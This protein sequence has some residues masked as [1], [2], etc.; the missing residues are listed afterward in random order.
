MKIIVLADDF[1]GAAEIAGIGVRYGLTAE[2]QFELDLSISASLIVVN[3]DTRNKSKVQ[4]LEKIVEVATQLK[5]AN[6]GIF[7]KVDSVM[8]GH[9][10]L[11]IEGLLQ[12]LKRNRA[13]LLP[14]NPVRGR[15]IIQGQYY[16]NEK[17]LEKS[18][19]NSDPTFPTVTSSLHQIMANATHHYHLSRGEV[20]PANAEHLILTGDLECKKDFSDYL[21]QAN[22][23]DLV[24]GAAECF[25]AYLEAQEYYEQPLAVVS[26]RPITLI[27]NGSTI[28]ND[29]VAEDST[30]ALPGQWVGDNFNISQEELLTWQKHVVQC[31]HEKCVGKVV[32]EHSVKS[33]KANSSL[34][35]RCFVALIQS[36]FEIFQSSNVTIGLT[37][38]AT[39]CGIMTQLKLT[40]LSVVGELASGVVCL[41]AE[42][43][44]AYFAVKPG[45]YAWPNTLLKNNI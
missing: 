13:I 23:T 3:T 35:E 10:I 4:A 15:K 21:A 5:Q 6:A 12:G 43:S 42:N 25:E 11:E 28:N 16:V 31:L 27:I 34:F 9:L 17:L 7:V 37:G 44:N 32:I 33:T 20:F 24:C 1:S 8:R 41:S 39:A 30:F 38:G 40:R 18:V 22:A 29:D 45:S 19:F 26:H 14:A 2:V 36:V